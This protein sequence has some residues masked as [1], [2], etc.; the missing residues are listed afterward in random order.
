MDFI[1]G[2]KEIKS[3]EIAKEIVKC[4]I[5]DE[6]EGNCQL[7]HNKWNKIIPKDLFSP[8]VMG[9]EDSSHM[10]YYP[11]F[12][13]PYEFEVNSVPAIVEVLSGNIYEKYSGKTY[14]KGQKI[15]FGPFVKLMPF[16]RNEE[17]RV[18]VSY[19]DLKENDSSLSLCL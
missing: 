1:F 8:M 18:R 9:L 12:S 2:T 7:E 17:A 6:Q 13:T 11:K 5:K 4:M 15:K 10:V 16:T 19:D 14:K 3:F